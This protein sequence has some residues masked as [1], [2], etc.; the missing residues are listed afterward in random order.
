MLELAMASFRHHQVPTIILEQP[1]DVAHLH[2]LRTPLNIEPEIHHI[3]LL[4]D[5][6]FAFQSQQTLFARGGI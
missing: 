6:V 2:L 4:H 1:E 5:V 3:A